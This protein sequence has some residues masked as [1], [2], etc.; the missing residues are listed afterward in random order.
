[1]RLAK[2]VW[3]ILVA[4]GSVW[5]FRRFS[6]REVLSEQSWTTV[7]PATA[8]IVVSQLG[9]FLCQEAAIA[10]SQ[11]AIPRR[12]NLRILAT[13]NLSKYLPL[14]G[15]NIAVNVV[16]LKRAGISNMNTTRAVLLL[17][18]WMVV[19]S[20]SLGSIALL[21]SLGLGGWP[22]ALI[23]IGTWVVIHVL[24][25]ERLVGISPAGPLPL[26]MGSQLLIWI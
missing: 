8:A 16:M 20:L 25:L 3:L 23:G 24:R 14:S 12:T 19:G 21:W 18:Y 17:T 15:T 5:F 11:Q 4:I 10:A 2:T 1:M 13:T 6:V 26:I 22:S 7:V 9:I